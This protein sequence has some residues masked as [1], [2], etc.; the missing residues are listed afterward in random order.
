MDVTRNRIEAILSG[1]QLVV[2]AEIGDIQA[3]QRDRVI[4]QAVQEM[5]QGGPE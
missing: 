4:R 3:W 5:A 1:V 2:D